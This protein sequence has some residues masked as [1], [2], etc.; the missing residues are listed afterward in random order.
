MFYFAKY[1]IFFSLIFLVGCANKN[2]AL[3]HYSKKDIRVTNFSDLASKFILD[4]DDNVV[5]ICNTDSSKCKK[6]LK[7]YSHYTHFYI[8]NNSFSPPFNKYIKITCGIGGISGYLFF[9]A[10]G[11][12]YEIRNYNKLHPE[13]CNS[14]FIKTSDFYLGRKLFASMYTFGTA[15]ISGGT[16]REV[17]FDKDKFIDAIYNSKV[18]L[19]SK[20][21]VSKHID[22]LNGDIDVFDIDNE[23][24]EDKY[25][26]LVSTSNNNAALLFL[27]DKE[28][29]FLDIF[30]K[31]KSDSVMKSISLQ[32]NALLNGIANKNIISYEKFLKENMPKKIPLPIIPPRKSLYKSEYETKAEFKK[33]V[34]K[35]LAKR[36]ELILK[37]QREYNEK[38]DKRNEEIENLKKEYA[39]YYDSQIE[40]KKELIEKIEEN[41]PMLTKILFLENI[42][43]SYDAKNFSYDAENK[44]LYFTIYLK[45]KKLPF[46]R[47]AV[48]DDIA[49]NVAKNIKEKRSFRFIPGFKYKNHNLI[50]THITLFEPISKNSYK[51]KYTNINFKPLVYTLNVNESEKIK[52]KAL[53]YF[54]SYKQKN[55]ILEV[56]LAEKLYFTSMIDSTNGR[57]PKW[58]SKPLKDRIIGFGEAQSLEVAKAKA[59]EDLSK[60]I[61]DK[62]NSNLVIQES[63]NNRKVYHSIKEHTSIQLNKNNYILYKQEKV[64]GIWYV[65]FEYKKKI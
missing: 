28:Y 22:K 3:E 25:D 5:F 55:I 65:G 37:L 9:L 35:Y 44:K 24:F 1:F 8:S 16:M 4:N 48:V 33:R 36:K 15:L 60:M 29:L 30:D 57:V 40:Q 11:T 20:I 14:R 19:Y 31:Y 39:N 63:L 62:I 51:I 42:N 38:V 64:D 47:K 21:L 10:K 7:D 41:I 2:I 53:K 12:K 52:V 34:E 13:I 26:D 43:N 58:F 56:P 18:P 17:V 59:R 50:L 27:Y 61:K 32:I 23:S 49:P 54:D 45:N 46:K 6:Y